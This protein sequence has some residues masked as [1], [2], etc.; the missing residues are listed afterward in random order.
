MNQDQAKIAEAFG[1]TQEQLDRYGREPYQIAY[2]SDEAR[3]AAAFG[4]MLDGAPPRTDG[5][6]APNGGNYGGNS[7]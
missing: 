6:Q 4:F 7:K 3:I 2:N 5:H 1:N